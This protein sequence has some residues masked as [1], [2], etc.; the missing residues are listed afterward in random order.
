MFFKVNNSFTTGS[1]QY[2]SFFFSFFLFTCTV[3][4]FKYCT[5]YIKSF[6]VYH[7][8]CFCILILKTSMSKLFLN[9]VFY[10]VLL[11][12]IF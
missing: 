6:N 1:T 12:V 10:K 9:L 4:T 7:A 2:C 3:H 5:S 11:K 8:N